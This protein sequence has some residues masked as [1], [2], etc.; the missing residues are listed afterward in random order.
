M[1]SL[2]PLILLFP[3]FSFSL[4]LTLSKSL[5]PPHTHTFFFTLPLSES[6][7]TRLL[8]AFTG[9]GH[10]VTASRELTVGGGGGEVTLQ[11]V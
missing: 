10:G 3:L 7:P 9:A 8:P 11:Q 5:L 6:I 2:P 1:P 4:P